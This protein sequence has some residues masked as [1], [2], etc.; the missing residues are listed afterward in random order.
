MDLQGLSA[1]CSDLGIAEEDAN[2]NR[3]GYSKSKYCLGTLPMS[4]TNLRLTA[5]NI[6]EM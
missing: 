1:I 3:I 6:S 4:S 2:G 5:K